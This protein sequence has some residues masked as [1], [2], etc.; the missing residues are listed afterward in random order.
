MKTRGRRAAFS[1]RAIRRGSQNRSCWVSV[2]SGNHVPVHRKEWSTKVAKKTTL[3]SDREFACVHLRAPL[4]T[5]RM[6]L[7]TVTLTQALGV[8]RQIPF[9]VLAQI[10]K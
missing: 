2:L 10:I 7:I 1:P 9:H 3:F 4:I 6:L 8:A 5:G